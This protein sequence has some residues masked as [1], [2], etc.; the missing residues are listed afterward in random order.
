MNRASSRADDQDGDP[1]IHGITDLMTS[2]AVV[3]ILLLA[4][5]VTREDEPQRD[6]VPPPATVSRIPADDAQVHPAAFSTEP[7]KPGVLSIVV[8][9]ARLHFETGKSAVLP[10]GEAFLAEAM[11]YY[12]SLVC[13]PDGHNVEAF[14]IEG[15][16]D[17]RG[18]ERQNLRLSQERSFAVMVK[19]LDIIRTSL[20]FAYDCFQRKMSA[21]GRG[22]QEPIL[23]DHGV[24]DRDQS[25]RVVFKIHFRSA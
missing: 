15:H 7:P 6:H 12:A 11:P 3:F 14:V 22:E 23:D 5:Y 10:M 18:D 13:G 24:V 8:P 1:T 20:P 16:T 21:N 2:L 9:D 19:G 17:D 4:A 25:R